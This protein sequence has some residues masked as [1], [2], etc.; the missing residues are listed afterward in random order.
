ME[1]GFVTGWPYS[2][3][4][5][6]KCHTSLILSRAKDPPWNEKKGR[7]PWNEKKGR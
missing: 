5:L 4:T 3:E 7:R 2:P 1:I 6:L